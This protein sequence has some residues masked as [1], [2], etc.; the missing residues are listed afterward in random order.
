MEGKVWSGYRR[1]S[2]DQRADE[3]DAHEPS[4]EQVRSGRGR[5]EHRHDQD[6]TRGL[7]PYTDNITRSLFTIWRTLPRRCGR[8]FYR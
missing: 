4:G 3:H 5:D 2:A 7:D 1:D 6:D 8:A